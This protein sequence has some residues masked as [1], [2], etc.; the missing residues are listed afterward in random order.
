MELGGEKCLD[1][2]YV[3]EAEAVKFGDDL[4]VGVRERKESIMTPKFLSRATGKL[5]LPL[6]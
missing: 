6:Y 5:K 3:L 1:Y 4:D 2:G